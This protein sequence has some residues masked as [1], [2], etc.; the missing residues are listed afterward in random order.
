MS[1]K[2]KVRV[3]CESYGPPRALIAKRGD[4]IEIERS[5]LDRNPGSFED[6]E[7]AEAARKTASEATRDPWFEQQREALRADREASA[8]AR[9]I[10]AKQHGERI[11]QQLA[12]YESQTAPAQ[13]AARAK[14]R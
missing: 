1:N 9:A 5:D 2:V 11:A 13:A 10:V 12:A 6:I 3:L 8:A 14:G 7:A 4:V